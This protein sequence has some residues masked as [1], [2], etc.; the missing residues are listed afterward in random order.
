MAANNPPPSGTEKNLGSYYRRPSAAIEQG[1][2]FFVPGLE[3]FRCA[4]G[5]LFRPQTHVPV[6]GETNMDFS[7]PAC[8]ISLSF[9]PPW[10]S[11]PLLL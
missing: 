7:L 6:S 9:S 11:K 4:P 2:G 5:V 1:G 3:G 10:V 8:S